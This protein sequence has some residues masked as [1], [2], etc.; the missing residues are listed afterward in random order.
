MSLIRNLLVSVVAELGN[1]NIF[2]TPK[3][4]NFGLTQPWIERSCPPPSEME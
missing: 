1:Q 4:V 3:A 2:I